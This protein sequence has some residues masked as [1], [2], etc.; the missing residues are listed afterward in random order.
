MQPSIVS[1]A[2]AFRVP[3][4]RDF[5]NLMSEIFMLVFTCLS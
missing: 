4:V 5:L 2:T 1:E 3:P